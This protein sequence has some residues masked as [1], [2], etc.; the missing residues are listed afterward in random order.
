MRPSR[1]VAGAG[2]AAVLALGALPG[3]VG[4]YEPK[5]DRPIDAGAYGQVNLAAARDRT[6]TREFVLD[7][8][9]RSQA[10]LSPIGRLVDP[11][12]VM[13]DLTLRRPP[14][15]SEAQP[16]WTWK[17]PLYTV[18]GFATFYDNGTTAMRLPRGTVVVVCGD[19]G[20][21]ERVITDYGPTRKGGRLIDLDR[22]DF[23]QVCGCP[24]WSGT[25]EVTVRVY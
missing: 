16:S 15:V 10:A 25:T 13:L 4:S 3:L 19:G 17:T 2:L 20:C 21:L 23:F 18:R 14:R 6:G 7:A 5:Q 11:A 8:A 9:G 12:R 24:G 1:T 22:P